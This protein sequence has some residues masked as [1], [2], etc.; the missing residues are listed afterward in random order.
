MWNNPCTNHF[1][2]FFLASCKLGMSC[3]WY[4]VNGLFHPYK[5]DDSILPITSSRTSSRIGTCSARCSEI[6]VWWE[7]LYRDLSGKFRNFRRISLPKPFLDVWKNAW[8]FLGFSD[9]VFSV[10][11]FVQICGAVSKRRVAV[12]VFLLVGFV[13]PTIRGPLLL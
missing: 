5:H 3:W 13:A 11:L 1:G 12:V 6:S 9:D 2:V 7:W 10:D 4:L 8:W